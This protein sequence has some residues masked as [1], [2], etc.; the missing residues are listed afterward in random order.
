VTHHSLAAR[1]SRPTTNT[2]T[3]LGCVGMLA[4]LVDYVV[5][6]DTHR[7]THSATVAAARSGAVDADVTIAANPIGYKRALRFAGHHAAG[8]RVGG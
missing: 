6:V 5:G 8:P 2:A 4:E 1:L 7:G 3:P